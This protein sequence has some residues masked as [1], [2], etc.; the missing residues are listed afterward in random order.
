[1]ATP[2]TRIR[3]ALYLV[4]VGPGL[5]D[6]HISATLLPW[7]DRVRILDG[8]STGSRTNLDAMRG[9]ETME[10]D[11]P[12]YRV[13]REAL[14]GCDFVLHQ[15]VLRSVPRAVNDP[16]TSDEPNVVAMKPGGHA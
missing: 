9:A 16:I 7:G 6:S 15:T 1:L 14:D 4:T 5:L 11:I 13:V 10:G 2:A 8:V 12:R 3:I